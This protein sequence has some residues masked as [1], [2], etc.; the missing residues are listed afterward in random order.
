MKIKD[1]EIWYPTKKEIIDTFANRYNIETDYHTKKTIDRLYNNNL[2][3]ENIEPK[4]N[5]LNIFRS[6][7]IPYPLNKIIFTNPKINESDLE[8]KIIFHN[9]LEKIKRQGKN[10]DYLS[11]TNELIRLILKE[12]DKEETKKY[13]DKYRKGSYDEILFYSKKVLD[14]LEINSFTKKELIKHNITLDKIINSIQEVYSNKDKDY[15]TFKYKTP[16]NMYVKQSL[17]ENDEGIA[18][19]NLKKDKIIYD[20]PYN[21]MVVGKVPS[22]TRTKF[23]ETSLFYIPITK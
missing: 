17:I 4:E 6:K 22:R 11:N 19:Y 10:I 20:G 2:I 16:N 15:L 12:E 8:K 5:K 9:G 18:L 21:D 7:D 14:N 1:K 13:I 3:N 23:N